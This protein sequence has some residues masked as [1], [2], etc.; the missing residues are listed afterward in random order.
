MRK[1][2][3]IR[4]WIIVIHFLFFIFYFSRGFAQY[5]TPQTTN[6][7]CGFGITNVTFN[8]IN[9]TSGDASN[10]YEDFTSVQTNV[11]GGQTYLISI[12]TD[13][14]AE[15]NIRV[16]IDYDDDK[17]FADPAELVFSADQVLAGNGSITIPSSALQGTNL[18]LRVSADFYT[19]PVPTPCL[20]LLQ[21]QAED[22][23]IVVLQNTNPPAV[24]FSVSDS[25]TC[26][27]IVSFTDQSSNLPTL[28]FWDFGD[29]NTSTQ[30]TPT[31]T[32]TTDGIYTV[33][34]IAYNAYGSDTM[35]KNNII[36]VN[37]GAQVI[38]PSCAPITTA[39][40]CDYGILNV[41]LNTINNST[42][43]GSE[44]YQDYSCQYST[45]LTAGFNYNLSITTGPNNPEDV[46]VWLDYNNDGV[47]DDPAEKIF[48]SLNNFTHSG[49]INLDTN[50]VL[51]T[52]LRMRI[53][54]DLVGASIT[55]CFNP[56]WGQVEDY[57]IIIDKFDDPP[58]AN[59]T[60][61]VTMACG[62][63]VNFTDLSTGLPNSWLWDFGDGTT[64]NQQNP[65][66]T[67]SSPGTYTVSLIATNQFGSHNITITNYITVVNAPLPPSCMPITTMYC[68]GIGIVQVDFNTI[69]NATQDGITSYEDFTCT[70]ITILQVNQT[71]SISIE[72]GIDYEEDVRAWIDWNNDGTLAPFGEE[73]FVSD[74]IFTVHF[75][76]ITVPTTA[77]LNT[78]LRMRVSSDWGGN[79]SPFPCTNPDYGQAEDY[80]VIVQNVTAPPIA[81]FS[82]DSTTVCLGA[83]SFTDLSTNSPVSWLWDFGDGNTTSAQNPSHTYNLNGTYTVSLTATNSLGNDTEIKTNYVTFDSLLCF[84]A[85]TANFTADSTIVCNGTVSFT[86]LSTSTPT[87]W[88]WDFGDGTTSIIQNPAHTYQNNGT[89]TVSLYASN[90]IGTDTLTVTGYITVDSTVCLPAPTATFTA[91]SLNNCLGMVNFSDLSGNNPT[92]W[93]WDFGD[94]NTDTVQNPTHTYANDGIYTVTL[95]ASNAN[96]TDTL[97]KVNYITVSNSFCGGNIPPVADFVVDSTLDCDGTVSFTDLSLYN[98]TSWEWDFGDGNTDSVQNPTHTYANDGT[99][100]VTLVVSNANGSDTLVQTNY[101]TVDGNACIPIPIANFTVDSQ[102]VCLGTVNFTDLSQN[103]PVS[104]SWDFGD[105]NTSTQQNPTHTYQNNGVYTVTLIATNAGGSDTEVKTNY[106]TVDNVLCITGIFES[107]KDNESLIVIYPNPNSGKFEV[108]SL[109]FE[110]TKIAVYNLLG[111]VVYQLSI[112]HPESSIEIDL[113]GN[114]KGVYFLNIQSESDSVSRKIIVQ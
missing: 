57:G 6:Y 93:L 45:T 112:Q 73:V 61:N 21:G 39:W 34:L 41:T 44:S 54:S 92:S 36:T 109:K 3:V 12:I 58:I 5:C 104:W 78:P 49:T 97:V 47:F 64:S 111:E 42:A 114:P 10:G 27:G 40:C 4:H 69:S 20:D 33:T 91:D 17:V 95:I 106:I 48:E 71:Y 101:V 24:D 26:D 35:V 94:G 67:Y 53:V 80:T 55:P 31:H 22:Y 63:P 75:G 1:L 52:A 38:T 79:P 43:D 103:N 28:W 99:Y 9:N 87:S 77:V 72:T 76:N 46:K 107:S 56:Q 15:H 7:C 89:Y 88:L 85:P 66:H 19:N 18:R 113:S 96:G 8:T 62:S 32:Y 16:W 105:G 98:P 82:V 84:S 110:V 68:C 65:S 74:D 13:I 90:S 108:R 59:F 50:G 37:L 25:L 23:T 102:I 70:D 14:P 86:D 51:D 2:L 29:G 30:Q 81:D 100:T 83:V 11:L 60:S